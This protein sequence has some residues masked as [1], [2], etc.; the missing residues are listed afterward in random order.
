MD[1]IEKERIKKEFDTIQKQLKFLSQEIVDKICPIK[2]GDIVIAK[3]IGKEIEEDFEVTL[4][5]PKF[6]INNIEGL[7]F[8]IEDPLWTLYGIKV[9]VDKEYPSVRDCMIVHGQ[10]AIIPPEVTLKHA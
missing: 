4:I 6:R 10:C 2:V 8:F 1:E 3:G 5:E 7:S 9:G